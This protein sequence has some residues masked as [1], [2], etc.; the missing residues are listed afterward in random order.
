[1]ARPVDLND[2]AQLPSRVGPSERVN[3][4]PHTYLAHKDHPLAPM[5]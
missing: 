4:Y 5:C 2:H 1:M 3:D